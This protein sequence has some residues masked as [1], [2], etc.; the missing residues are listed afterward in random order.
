MSCWINNVS[1]SAVVWRQYLTFSNVMNCSDRLSKF[2]HFLLRRVSCSPRRR[3]QGSLGI[4]P[5]WKWGWGGLCP[6]METGFAQEGHVPLW[7]PRWVCSDLP[8]NIFP[9]LIPWVLEKDHKSPHL[10]PRAGW[11]D[12]PSQAL[13]LSHQSTHLLEIAVHEKRRIIRDFQ[14]S[15]TDGLFSLV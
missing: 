7:L 2:L 12:F 11:K 9:S 8:G 3:R 13:D 4:F 10:H 1:P 14:R 6:I 15:M 5:E